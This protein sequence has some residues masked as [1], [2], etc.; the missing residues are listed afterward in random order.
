MPTVVQAEIS[1]SDVTREATTK[2]PALGS[3]S[4]LWFRFEAMFNEPHKLEHKNYAAKK[5]PRQAVRFA[6]N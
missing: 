1:I 6:V 4:K 2:S 3:H 5:I